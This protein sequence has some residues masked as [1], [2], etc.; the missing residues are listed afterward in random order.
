[1]GVADLLVQGIRRRLIEW[2]YG[3]TEP[4]TKAS[5]PLKLSDPRFRKVFGIESD[6]TELTEPF[7]QLPI[8]RAAITAKASNIACDSFL[9][10]FKS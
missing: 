7:K 8:I 3:P 5:A 9:K 2:A 1:M 6:Q 10:L 4:T